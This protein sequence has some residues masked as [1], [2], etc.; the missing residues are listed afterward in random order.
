MVRA[1]VA[2]GDS[3]KVFANGVP[4]V[5][6]TTEA[7]CQANATLFQCDF[8]RGQLQLHV[9]IATVRAVRFYAGSN[10]PL[11]FPLRSDLFSECLRTTDACRGIIGL[12]PRRRMKTE[13]NQRGRQ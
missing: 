9:V 12:F 8:G 11:L 5:S 13:T 10:P 2:A 3:R 4:P 1:G 7:L 6:T